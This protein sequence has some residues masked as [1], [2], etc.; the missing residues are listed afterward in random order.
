M[1]QT[2]VIYVCMRQFNM[3]KTNKRKKKS[4]QIKVQTKAAQV[5]CPH[6]R[7]E[8]RRGRLA[9]IR[10]VFSMSQA[11]L[12]WPLAFL[13]RATRSR[14]ISSR[15]FFHRRYS[16]CSSSDV[17]RCRSATAS[18]TCRIISASN[19]EQNLPSKACRNGLL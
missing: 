15:S 17:M 2:A 4:N 11:L 19:T 7:T 14:S 12:H 6:V 16:S 18:V 9:Y 13:C 5:S 1:S 3:Q 10:S 8:I